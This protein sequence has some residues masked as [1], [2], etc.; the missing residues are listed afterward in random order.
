M[1]WQ[2][3]HYSMLANTC[4][5]EG[6]TQLISDTMAMIIKLQSSIHVIS[7]ILLVCFF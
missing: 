3:I 4:M 6:I 2:L 1:L 7:E 5:V